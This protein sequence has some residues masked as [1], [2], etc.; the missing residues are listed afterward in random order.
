MP[1]YYLKGK[2]ALITGASKGIG[3]GIAKSLANEGA[4]LL[5]IARTK[6]DLLK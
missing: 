5:L 3:F 2:T 1:N 4:N 6:K